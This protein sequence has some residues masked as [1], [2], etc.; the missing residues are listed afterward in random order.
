MCPP[1]R[2][3]RVSPISFFRPWSARRASRR[4]LFHAGSYNHK[5]TATSRRC[6][7]LI[8]FGPAPFVLAG[9][10]LHLDPS[11]ELLR[12]R[13]HPDGNRLLFTA[14]HRKTVFG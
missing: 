8:G 7:Q 5:F 1:R 12:L 2:L 10:A 14:G 9:T 6:A 13:I 4:Q 3:R 11:L